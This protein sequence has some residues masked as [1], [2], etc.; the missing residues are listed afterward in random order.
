MDGPKAVHF[1]S[2]RGLFRHIK[3]ANTARTAMAGDDAAC[4]RG[5]QI[6][7]W[8][9]FFQFVSEVLSILLRICVGDKH[10]VRIQIFEMIA[11]IQQQ[12]IESLF[13]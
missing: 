13:T 12:A 2:L 3:N 9:H 1:G 10:P 7:N 11:K 6:F 8:R 5:M 4:K